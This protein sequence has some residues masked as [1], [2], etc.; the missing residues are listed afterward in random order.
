MN[1][2]ESKYKN[3]DKFIEKLK[4]DIE[5][6]EE[7]IENLKPGDYFANIKDENASWTVS[8]STIKNINVGDT[9]WTRGVITETM[10]LK[11]SKVSSYNN[12]K[13]QNKSIYIKK[14]GNN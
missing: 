10:V 1:T 5:W 6:R 4:Q 13:F 14:I 2:V 12:I 7:I 3:P 9:V 11:S 8:D